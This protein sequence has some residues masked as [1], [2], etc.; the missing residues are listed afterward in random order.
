MNSQIETWR[1]QQYAANVYQLAQQKGSR[2]AG[3]VRKEQFKGKAEFFDRLGL[4][5]AQKKP[6]RNSDTPNLDIAHSRRMVTTE[7]YEWATLV[8]RK[9]KLENI[10]SPENEYAVCA[11]NALGRSMDDILIASALGTAK[12]GESGS[13]NVVLANTNKVASLDV[14]NALARLNIGA[15][16]NVKFLFDAAEVE[17]A[18]YIVHRAIDLQNLLGETKVTSADYNSVKALVSGEIDTFLGFKFIRSERL[19]LASVYDD[20][21]FKFG[22][23]GLYSSGGTAV[24]ATDRQLLAFIGDGLLLGMQEQMTGRIDERSDKSYSSQVYASMDLG[25][26]RM[27]EEKVV[28]ILVKA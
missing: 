16:L 13:S 23:D 22:T 24:Q 9:D 4:A 26:V 15:L 25:G 21:V 8:D 5:T 12:A 20:S 27:E 11:R 6:S 7:M 1:V 18:R 17:G 3:L 2:L 28:G 14:S 19:P 10:H